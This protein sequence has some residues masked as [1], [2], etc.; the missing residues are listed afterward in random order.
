MDGDFGWWQQVGLSAYA[1]CC[2]TA[3]CNEGSQ[4]NLAA[5]ARPSQKGPFV[6]RFAKPN[7]GLGAAK[8]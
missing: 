1:T 4:P 8:V 3:F 5:L 6:E 7:I 2:G